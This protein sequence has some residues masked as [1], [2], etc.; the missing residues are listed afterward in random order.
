[1]LRPLVVLLLS[2]IG[3]TVATAQTAFPTEFPAASAPL[4]P[5]ALKQALLGR[6]FV[7]KPI[8]GQPFR[9][10]YKDTYVFI[11]VGATKDT[12]RWRTEGSSVCIDWNNLRPSCSEMRAEGSVL[13]VKRA[14]NGEVVRL[15]EQ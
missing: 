14:N 13:Y 4:D 7:A 6:T 10:Q 12:G 1:M 15:E 3:T 9:I 8:E 11:N 2:L 5:A